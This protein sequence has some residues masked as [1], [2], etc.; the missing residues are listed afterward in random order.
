MVMVTQLSALL[1]IIHCMPNRMNFMICK[2]H[3][4][5]SAKKKK[6]IKLVGGSLPFENESNINGVWTNHLRL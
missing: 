6:E 3:L 1:K 2:L 5:K 4:Q